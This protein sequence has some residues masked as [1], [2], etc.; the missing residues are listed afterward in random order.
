MRRKQ[1]KHRLT[2]P[3]Q[4]NT[5]NDYNTYQQA[6]I[7]ATNNYRATATTRSIINLTISTTHSNRIQRY[8][9]PETERN[10]LKHHPVRLFLHHTTKQTTML[11]T[12]FKNS[13]NNSVQAIKTHTHDIML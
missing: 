8:E 6:Y 1:K 12:P 11:A 10:E 4:S 7:M 13:L 5:D 9:T 3:Q 2:S